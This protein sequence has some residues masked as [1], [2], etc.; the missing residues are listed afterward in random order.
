MAR[1]SRD[2]Y[3][4]DD[5][6]IDE[7]TVEL[8][9]DRFQFDDSVSGDFDA[10]VVVK[11][12]AGEPDTLVEAPGE[13]VAR[14]DNGG[15]VVS[16]STGDGAQ[17]FLGLASSGYAKVKVF[18]GKIRKGIARAANTSPCTLCKKSVALVM[19]AFLVAAGVPAT[20]GLATGF[21]FDLSGVQ[22]G[23]TSFFS[24]VAN[25]VLGS[26]LQS[27]VSYLSPNWGQVIEGFLQGLNWI[28]EPAGILY[29]AACRS[30]SL[31]P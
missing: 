9:G 5:I 14:D 10:I 28:F 1:F 13:E 12:I 17:I 29:E 8:D 11:A 23:L 25:G 27:V 4:D 21:G 22:A 26:A 30:F 31:C 24:D 3:A 20:P 15:R 16:I 18:I 2:S 7:Y 19:F 6:V